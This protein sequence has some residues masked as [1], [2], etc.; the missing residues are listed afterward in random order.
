MTPAIAP[1]APTVGSP[2]IEIERNVNE[3]GGDAAENVEARK[4]H[5]PHG[6]FDTLAEGPQEKHVADDVPPARMHEHATSPA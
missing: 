4:F 2:R 3:P 6:V 5:V 1:L